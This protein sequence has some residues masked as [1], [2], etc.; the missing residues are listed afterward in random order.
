MSGPPLAVGDWVT[1]TRH[2]HPRYGQIGRVLAVL[3]YTQLVRGR[4]VREQV[5]WRVQVKFDPRAD[6]DLLF[7][8]ALRRVEPDEETIYRWGLFELTR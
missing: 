6:A 2:R 5:P 3:S 7:V 8:D 4:R 1:L